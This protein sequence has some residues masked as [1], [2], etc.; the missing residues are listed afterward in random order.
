MALV[1]GS[2]LFRKGKLLERPIDIT[3]KK[4]VESHDTDVD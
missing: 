1:R 4:T 3:A 2:A